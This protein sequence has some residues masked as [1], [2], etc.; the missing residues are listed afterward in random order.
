M[1]FFTTSAFAAAAVA[2]A[3]GRPDGAGHSHDHSHG[4]H[5]AGSAVSA[6]SGGG[7]CYGAPDSGYGA[8]AT[9]YGTPDT[10]YGEPT[11]YSGY[12]AASSGYDAAA[13]SGYEATGYDTTYEAASSGGGGLGNL[14]VIIIPL[15][16]VAGI[17]LLFPQTSQ[18]AVRRK[19]DV[20]GQ[21]SVVERVQDIYNSLVE[22]EECMERVACELGGLV[23]D[24]G[25]DNTLTRTAQALV[26]SKY[27]KYMK[28]FATGK[29][30][31]KIKCGNFF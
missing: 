8:P 27:N 31:Q 20:S 16:I 6:V 3:S 15:L 25:I 2:L 24:M 19:R 21:S 4:G 29:E 10:G 22:S 11:G 7:S 30:C 26:P 5:D 28:N 14:S 23:N 13:G 1:K 17:F 18:V 12:E 9:G